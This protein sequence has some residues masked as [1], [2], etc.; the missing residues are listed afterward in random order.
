MDDLDQ[1]IGGLNTRVIL[2]RRGVHEVLADV[3]FDHFTDEPFQGAPAG[4][5]LLQH[6]GALQIAGDG[7]LY[8]VHRFSSFSFSRPMCATKQ[9]PLDL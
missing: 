1:L 8:R 2:G 5:G 6:P 9:D 3:I 7:A 4:G